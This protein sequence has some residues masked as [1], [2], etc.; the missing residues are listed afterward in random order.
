[1]I[2]VGASGLYINSTQYH[3]GASSFIV[4]H[5]AGEI[6]LDLERLQRLHHSM[7]RKVFVRH[8]QTFA[9]VTT[10]MD[11][12]H[13]TLNLFRGSVEDARA[14]GFFEIEALVRLRRW[15]Q[16]PF[17][18]ASVNLE[19]SFSSQAGSF[20]LTRVCVANGYPLI[21]QSSPGDLLS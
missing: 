11:S 21:W 2:V 1:M 15:A 3:D 16:R 5:Q 20:S 17:R 9:W 6:K 10:L 18:F 19:S 12:F 13:S 8:L 4:R 7:K 14:S